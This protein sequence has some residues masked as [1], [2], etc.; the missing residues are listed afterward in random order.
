MK[1]MIRFSA[2]F[3]V[4]MIVLGACGTEKKSPPPDKVTVQL[5]WIHQAQFAGLYVA[6]EQGY[7]A[8]EHL[9]VMF[10][11]GGPGIDLVGRVTS[12]QADFGVDGADRVLAARGEGQPVVAIAVIFRKNPFA[13]VAL[14]DSGITKPADFLG[15]T[16]AI[17]DAH[18]D[19]QFK[20]M[21]TNLGLDTQQVTIIPYLADYSN[22]YD[23]EADIT[24]GYSTGGLIRMR[25]AGYDINLIWPSDYSVHFYADTLITT[26]QLI[27]AESRPGNP[28]PTCNPQRLAHGGRESDDCRQRDVSLQRRPIRRHAN[29]DVRR[30]YPPG[31][32]RRGS[33]RLDE[34]RR[35][36]RDV[37]GAAGTG[38]AGAAL[39]RHQRLYDEVSHRHLRRNTM[40]LVAKLIVIFLLL[41]I[42]P[43]TLVGYLAFVDGRQAIEQDTTDRLLTTT[44]LKEAEFTS[45]LDD[46]MGDME[47]LAQRPLIRQFTA[48]LVSQDPASPE[49]RAAYDRI[50]QDHF[51]PYLEAQTNFL[52]FSI[53]RA[54]DGL[55]LVSTREELEGK[56]REDEAFFIEGQQATYIGNV[57]YEVTLSEQ[58]M[59]ISTPVKD[60]GGAVI[61]V[62]VGHLNLADISDIMTRRT[63]LR[64]TEETYLVNSFNFMVTESRFEPGASLKKAVY[65]EGVNDCLAHHDG[66]GFYDD[67][68]GVPVIG[69]YRWMPE[70]EMC[71]VT[72]IEQ[73]EALAPTLDLRSSIF[74]IGLVIGLGVT[75]VGVFFARTITTPVRQ[76]VKGTGEIGQGHL[77]Y[78]VGTAAKDEIGQ[79]SRA[80][81]QMA[82]TLK[83]TTVSRD[84]LAQ[85]VAERRRSEE[86][87]RES[88]KRYH[89]TLDAM[90]EGC[91]II[92][93]D[94][95]YLYLNDV[96][97]RHNRRPKENLLG[98][99]YMD[100][101]PDIESTKV[102]AVLK[103]TMEEHVPQSMENQFT[104]PDGDQGWFEL[105]IYAVPEGIVI[106]SVDITER[107]QAE[108]EIHRLNAE[109][110]QRVVER[111][112]QLEAA[113]KELE[114]FSYSVSHDLRAPL[115]A[116]DGFSRILIEEYAPELPGEAQRYLGMVR[117]NAQQ[118][119]SLIDHLLAFSRLGR[120]PLTKQR[121]EPAKLV[122]NALDELCAEQEGRN[123][124]IT[125][126]D[127]PPC[128]AD[129]ALLQRVFANLLGNAMKFTKGRDPAII[130]VG[131]DNHAGE[132]VCF[133]KDNGVGFDMQYADKMFGVF[134]RLH[135]AEDYEGSGVGLA[136]VQRIILRHG[137]RI[138]AES[139]VDKGATFYFTLS[140]EDSP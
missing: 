129:P 21:M 20:A 46:D 4:V 132:P 23:G 76:L 2:A 18:G 112:A 113:N 105:K 115:R 15:H 87:L 125:V 91:Q 33:D 61:A 6:Q 11:E 97:D 80:F 126:G 25:R 122:Q 130:E 120:Q 100:M 103:Q 69:A 119:G 134:Q 1:A 40:S 94:W 121:V 140:G 90:L 127:L 55:I 58:V 74:F 24:L 123:I 107:K 53:I 52:D 128:Q 95:R 39:R 7:Y 106:L 66:T 49:Y 34:S 37:P 114:A 116:M 19:L 50:R 28:L 88:E 45:W 30:S 78:R 109:L 138:W 70:R 89:H 51:L 99:R 48:V 77:D 86:A 110:E 59:H 5:K 62:L 9:S 60:E 136:T 16:A 43:L 124:T 82:E 41:S 81:D 96:A 56:Y 137:G 72:E 3:L 36:E 54:S 35:V 68:R 139:E 57:N 42:V 108:E 92:G 29:R 17:G 65:T 84:E 93:H 98:R 75:G 12:G 8:D 133:V 102:F 13:F 26:D 14:A 31:P 117:N 10:V 64:K 135:R 85:E 22:F 101:W 63:G 79:L 27:A 118:M 71:I 73:S 47:L 83:V 38:A 104:F 111:T 44:L 32:Y 131:C 67:Y